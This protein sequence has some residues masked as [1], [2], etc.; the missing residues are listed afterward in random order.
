M[1]GRRKKETAAAAQPAPAPAPTP[2]PIKPS[3]RG[4]EAAARPTHSQ[5][6]AQAGPSAVEFEELR[7]LLAAKCEEAEDLALNLRLAKDS[8]RQLSE[9]LDA[10]HLRAEEEKQAKAVVQRERDALRLHNT[11]LAEELEAA[12]EE[13]RER[14]G[15]TAA[16]QHRMHAFQQ[17]LQGRESE[18]ASEVTLLSDRLNNSLSLLHQRE[19]RIERLTGEVEEMEEGVAIG[20]VH[21][22][23]LV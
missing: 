7:G 9:E 19:Q 20:R 21:I 1:W 13:A 6:K 14:E 12:R 22:R 8:L 11:Q 4:E 18:L 3:G 2:S 23:K 5:P 10:T 17:A 16:L 15:R